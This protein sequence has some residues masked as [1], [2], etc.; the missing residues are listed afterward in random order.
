VTTVPVILVVTFSDDIHALA[1]QWQLNA[2]RNHSC[3]VLEVDR[4]PHTGRLSWSTH[5]QGHPQ[6]LVRGGHLLDVRTVTAIWWRRLHMI[7]ATSGTNR[8]ASNIITNDS[9][10]ALEGMLWNENRGI[11]IN[12]PDANR[13]A[14]NKLNQLQVAQSA[15]FRIP[16]TLV[17]QDPAVIRD[18]CDSLDNNVVIKSVRGTSQAALLT[19]PV[20]ADL[21]ASP[22]ALSACPAI[23]QERIDGTKHIRANCFGERV[24]AF[25]IESPRLDWRTDLSVPIRPIK[26]GLNLCRR[27]LATLDS[28]GL[29]MG[30][31]DL[32]IDSSGEPV[33]LE[34]NP[35]GQFL[36][37]SGITGVDILTPFADFL[38]SRANFS[39]QPQRR[40]KL[41]R[42]QP[43]KL[44]LQAYEP[45][46]RATPSRTRSRTA[47]P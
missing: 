26:L 34:V 10:A 30:I 46:G 12:N 8:V 37:L 29:E 5:N 43:S 14:E 42:P 35:Q 44:P 20:T 45:V 40:R 19:M 7:A 22:A 18:F 47:R 11:W 23:Y 6:V 13:K 15:G 3:H 39:S 17:S 1:L 16:K 9:R 32:K 31:F 4:L 21:L 38:C 33:W 2:R 36:F 27:L 41:A 28:L 24:I 25:E